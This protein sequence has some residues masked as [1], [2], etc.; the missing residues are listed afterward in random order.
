[1][2]ASSIVALPNKRFASEQQSYGVRDTQLYAL[3]LGI[4]QD[5]CDA[6]QLACLRA[7]NPE[8]VPTQAAVLAASSAWMRDADNAIDWTQLV[9]LSHSIELDRGLPAQGN[10]ESRLVVSDV[11]DRGPGRGAIIDWSREL[12]GEDGERL[13][14]VRGR[15]LARG[16][17]GFG[18]ARAAGFPR[19]ILHGLCSLGICAFVVAR[20]SAQREC[21]RRILGISGRYAGVAYPG[22]S[23][24]VDVWKPQQNKS[25]FRCTAVER[26][27][28]VIAD[29]A[30]WFDPP[31]YPH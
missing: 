2:N 8:V 13:A 25:R 31:P 16:N 24:R 19:P 30:A 1:V 28:P 26:E 11:R 7:G 5:P 21:S 20:A 17:G 18:A 14:I 12:F 23:L 10:V 15:A 9:A 29:G 3:G 27:A 22:E 6:F 4:G